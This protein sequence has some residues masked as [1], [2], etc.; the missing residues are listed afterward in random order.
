MD[1]SVCFWALKIMTLQL[2][3]MTRITRMHT[4]TIDSVFVFNQKGDTKMLHGEL[5]DRKIRVKTPNLRVSAQSVSS[6]F[7]SV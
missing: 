3:R 1:F 2:G 7:P 6:V 5:T 4:D